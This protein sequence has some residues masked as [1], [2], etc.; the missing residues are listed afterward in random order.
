[1]QGY[2]EEEALRYIARSI[3]RKAFSE[4]G[5]SI[6][7]M[8][9]QAQALDLRYMRE[10][11]VIDGDG[12]MGDGFYDDD[13]AFEFIVEEIVRMRGLNEEGAVLVASLIDAYMSAHDAFL[14]K[15][16]LAE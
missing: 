1:M 11:D 13:E 8:L 16:G 9:R 5:P 7:G 12:F 14:R 4:I 15:A 3:D 6:D 2:N 10:N